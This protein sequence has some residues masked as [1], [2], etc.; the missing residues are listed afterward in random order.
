MKPGD[1]TKEILSSLYGTLYV[2]VSTNMT[3]VYCSSKAK[4]TWPFNLQCRIYLCQG[5]VEFRA[6]GVKIDAHD[7]LASR[8]ECPLAR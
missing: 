3:K 8:R 2:S 1:E 6:P 7:A 5:H 4:I